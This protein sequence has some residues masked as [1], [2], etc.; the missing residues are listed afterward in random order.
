VERKMNDFDCGKIS[1]GNFSFEKTNVE[2]FYMPGPSFCVYLDGESAGE[3][4]NTISHEWLHHAIQEN[5]SYLNTTYRR[6][7]CK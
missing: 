7:F 1:K 2:G 4:E 5:R 6:H 3:V